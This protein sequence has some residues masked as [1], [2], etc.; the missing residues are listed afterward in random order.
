MVAA[1]VVTT[2][3][4]TAEHLPRLLLLIP[5]ETRK[6]KKTKRLQSPCTSRGFYI[7]TF[8]RGN[9]EYNY[10]TASP[11]IKLTCTAIRLF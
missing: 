4:A 11:Q 2:T 9:F 8:L 7:G 3:A 5:A 6:I 10:S 1:A